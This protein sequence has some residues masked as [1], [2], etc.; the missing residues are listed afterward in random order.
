MPLP[1]RVGLAVLKT[2]EEEL[3]GLP[4]EQL[5]AALNSKRFPAFKKPPDALLKAALGTRVSR[6][7]AAYEV[8][9]KQMTGKVLFQMSKDA[10][11]EGLGLPVFKVPRRA[12]V[13]I[14]RLLLRLPV[15]F[16]FKV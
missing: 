11:H 14:S 12:A 1:C 2:A 7:L 3:L 16:S 9:Y 4:F 15:G 5:L 8:E 13:D 10:C 6:R